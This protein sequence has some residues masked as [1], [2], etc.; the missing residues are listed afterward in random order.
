MNKQVYLIFG[1]FFFMCVYSI[2]MLVVMAVFGL[3]E[4]GVLSDLSKDRGGYFGA[5]GGPWF[6]G[7]PTGSLGLAVNVWFSLFLV[8]GFWW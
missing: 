1:G 8:G 2:T 7:V 3:R 4:C 5:L 6:C